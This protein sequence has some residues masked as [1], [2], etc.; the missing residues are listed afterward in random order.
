[1][2]KGARLALE[3]LMRYRKK[4]EVDWEGFDG[5]ASECSVLDGQASGGQ[6][7]SRPL[8]SKGGLAGGGAGAGDTR[9]GSR[10]QRIEV[11]EIGE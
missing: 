5:K 2:Q 9:L 1:V 10:K 11:E 6:C 3:T 4:V 7:T 8:V